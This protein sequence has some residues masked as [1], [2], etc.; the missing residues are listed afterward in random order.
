MAVIPAFFAN[1]PSNSIYIDGQ[2]ATMSSLSLIR[3]KL[4]P[5]ELSILSALMLRGV[6]LTSHL[7]TICLGEHTPTTERRIQRFGEK[8]EK[9]KALKRRAISRVHSAGGTKA[10]LW[11]LTKLGLKLAI[12]DK[13]LLSEKL[14]YYSDDTGI[15]T[16][17]HTLDINDL[18]I[19]LL[20]TQNSNIGFK[21][22]SIER[23]P[24]CWRKFS[25]ISLKSDMLTSTNY[26]DKTANW[27]IELDRGTVRPARII[28][29]C[30]LYRDYIIATYQTEWKS[31]VPAVL[32]VVPD[33][34]RAQ[35][36][37][38][39]VGAAVGQFAPLFRFVTAPDFLPEILGGRRV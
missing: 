38:A 24:Y 1:A 39:H 18:E 23:E 7:A 9:M 36:L 30:L 35:R 3:S 27:F 11:Q 6:M 16:M 2:E 19:K 37:K 25:G 10:L 32:W 33:Q 5:L 21:V 14:R 29:K 20:E 22:E 28:D 17:R 31:G 8:L 26:N 15:A 4:S 12:T 34:L 13:R